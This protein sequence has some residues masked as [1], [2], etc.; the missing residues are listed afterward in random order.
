MQGMSGA[1][2]FA[3]AIQEA[4]AQW[5]RYEEDVQGLVQ[6]WINPRHK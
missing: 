4:V 6:A 5:N 2:S 3:E 1:A